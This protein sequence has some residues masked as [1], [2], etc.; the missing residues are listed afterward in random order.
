[1]RS[2]LL[3]AAGLA[4]LA[5]TAFA[6]DPAGR[7]EA[8]AFAPHVIGS[9]DGQPEIHRPAASS[10]DNASSGVGRQAGGANDTTITYSGPARGT[11]GFT[12]PPRIVDNA[13]GQPVIE[14]GHRPAGSR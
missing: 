13:D 9:S 8:G 5:G 10:H 12:A 6:H 14:H 1:M 11:L 4:V 3:L 2:S 7:P